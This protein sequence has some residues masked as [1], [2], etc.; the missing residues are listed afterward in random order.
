M[1]AAANPILLANVGPQLAGPR[2]GI[3]LPQYPDVDGDGFAA[4]RGDCDDSDPEIHLFAREYCDGEDNDC[5]GD[6]D[7]GFDADG[8]GTADCFDTCPQLMDFDTDPNGYTLVNGQDMSQ[9]YAWWGIDIEVYEQDGA[10]SGLPIAFDSSNPLGDPDLGTPNKDFGGP[11]H[12]DGGASG[13]PGQNDTPL[14]NLLILAE[15]TVDADGDGLVDLPDDDAY[16]AWFVFRFPFNTCVETLDL[17]DIESAEVPAEIYLYESG[18]LVDT[19]LAGGLGDN[20]VEHV[21][22]E[23]CEVDEMVIHTHGSGAVDNVEICKEK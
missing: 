14:Y 16:G 12:G 19:V 17:I 18:V 9:A 15:N 11:G 7:E 20:S 1:C 13:Q 10:T 4:G 22:V 23:V 5:D 8:D 2:H 21:I 6:V 3:G